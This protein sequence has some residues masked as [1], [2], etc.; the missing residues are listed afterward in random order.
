MA[1]DQETLGSIL[2]PINYYLFLV[3]AVQ[4]SASVIDIHSF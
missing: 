2:G 3:S 1:G 4:L